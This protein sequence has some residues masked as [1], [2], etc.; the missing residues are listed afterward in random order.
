ETYCDATIACEGNLYPIHRFVISTCSTYFERILENIS[1]KNPIIVLVGIKPKMI[2]HLLQY[3]YTGE[4]KVLQ[5]DIDSLIRAGE[6][7]KIKGIGVP[8]QWGKPKKQKSFFSDCEEKPEKRQR[9]DGFGDSLRLNDASRDS[10]DN[11]ASNRSIE[12]CNEGLGQ[13]EKE[14]SSDSSNHPIFE[15]AAIEEEIFQPS[16]VL[17]QKEAK[18]SSERCIDNTNQQI[19]A[20]TAVKEEILQPYV[21]SLHKVARC[22]SGGFNEEKTPKELNDNLCPSSQP[23]FEFAAVKEETLQTNDDSTNFA[24]LNV[25]EEWIENL[26]N[27]EEILS[28]DTDKVI[29]QNSVLSISCYRAKTKMKDGQ[30]LFTLDKECNGKIYWKCDD[31]PC[32]SRIHTVNGEIVKRINPI[33][34]HPSVPGKAEVEEILASMKERASNTAEPISQIVNTFYPKVDVGWTHLLPAVKSIKRTLQ[35]ARKKT[36]VSDFGQR[37]KHI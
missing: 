24:E 19:T 23:I 8:D 6:L 26:M 34:T 18:S 12:D 30:H 22:S 4:V 10:K 2:E 13:K 3:M 27:E 9:T 5:E 28:T 33:H 1:E 36:T 25:K 29:F 16:K 17:L 11:K 37:I 15:N 20:F 31:I 32:R 14:V 35:R 21:E 7:L